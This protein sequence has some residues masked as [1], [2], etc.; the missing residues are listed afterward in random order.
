MVKT[1]QTQTDWFAVLLDLILSVTL[2]KM[3]DSIQ[4]VNEFFTRSSGRKIKD[5]EQR[6]ASTRIF[7]V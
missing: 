4:Y 3:F 5:G 6:F 7:L 1:D 2:R